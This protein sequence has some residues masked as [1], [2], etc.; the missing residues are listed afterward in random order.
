MLRD[1]A[2]LNELDGWVRN[3]PDGSV[4]AL[5]QGEEV[6]VRTVVEWARRGPPGSRVDSLVEQKLSRYWERLGFEI[7]D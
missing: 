1:H 2:L 4:E 7:L 5:L 6:N 3:T